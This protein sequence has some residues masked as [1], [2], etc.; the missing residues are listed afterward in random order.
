[1]F[2][3]QYAYD[4]V[5]NRTQTRQAL[6]LL[7]TQFA[8]RRSYYDGINREV[9]TLTAEGYLTE[10]VYD[11]VGNRTS[12]TQHDQKIVAPADGSRP[13]PPA[14][15]AGR[16][17]SYWYDVNNRLT[18]QTSALGIST[19]HSYDARGNRIATTEAAG[20]ADARTTLLRYDAADRYVETV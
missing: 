15:D 3:T 9:A 7:G 5:G 1:G 12:R 18:R 10:N 2:I 19:E 14:G 6:D 4:A 11:A 8:I 16:T 13:A 17:T 20:T